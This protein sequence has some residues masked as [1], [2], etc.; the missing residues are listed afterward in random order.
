MNHDHSIHKE[1]ICSSIPIHTLETLHIPFPSVCSSLRLSLRL[2]LHSLLKCILS[3]G[4]ES[5]GQYAFPLLPPSSKLL[6]DDRC[7]SSKLP[8]KCQG[9]VGAAVVVVMVAHGA[10]LMMIVHCALCVVLC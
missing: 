7:Y 9:K 4:P 1:S 8:G 3:E 10:R 2:F 5:H 6:A